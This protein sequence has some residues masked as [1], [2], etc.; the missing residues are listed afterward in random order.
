M[1]IGGDA[2]P[3]NRFAR[4]IAGRNGAT[5]VLKGFRSVVAAP[6]GRIAR[7]LA[8]TQS[9]YTQ[10]VTGTFRYMAPETWDPAMK[11]TPAVDIYAFGVML[12]EALEGRPPFNAEYPAIINQHVNG[13][14]PVPERI[15][16]EYGQNA[17]AAV[18]RALA[19]NAADRPK[20]ALDMVRELHDSIP[21]IE[22]LGE[23]I[24]TYQITRFLGADRGSGC[25][26]RFFWQQAADHESHPLAVAAVYAAIR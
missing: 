5:V 11:K 17:A 13:E 22:F 19:K 18:T 12:Y 23:R 8:G 6:S 4:G 9:F 10:N 15:L 3:G 25:G 2:V 21:G 16:R 7:V 24:G 14:I 1:D 26:L 20:S